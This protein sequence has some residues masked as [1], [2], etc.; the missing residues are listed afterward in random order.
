VRPPLRSPGL[1]R[2]F[3]PGTVV[4]AIV[5]ATIG[6]TAILEVDVYCPDSRVESKSTRKRVTKEYIEILLLSW[7]SVFWVKAEATEPGRR[8]RP[9]A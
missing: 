3:P 9:A 5:G 8:S 1:S 6:M 4:I 2:R 7:R